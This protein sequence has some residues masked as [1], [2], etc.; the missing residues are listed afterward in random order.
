MPS[1]PRYDQPP[2]DRRRLDDSP[3]DADLPPY[4][5]PPRGIKVFGIIGAV[6]VLLLAI[7]LAGGHHGFGR[8]RGG[9]G[10][11]PLPVQHP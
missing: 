3:A 7:L 6:V 9:D 11:H 8:H 4:P 1:G 5:G 10:G 2:P